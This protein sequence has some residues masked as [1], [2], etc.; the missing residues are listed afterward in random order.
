[1]RIRIALGSVMLLLVLLLAGCGG[2]ATPAPSDTPLPTVQAK[3]TTALAQQPTPPAEPVTPPVERPTATPQN[4]EIV[5]WTV[6]PEGWQEHVSQRWAVSFHVPEDWQEAEPD[7]LA[8]DDGYAILGPFDGPGTSVDQACEWLANYR[9]DL[10][11]LAAGILSV[12][13]ENTVDVGYYPCLIMGGAADGGEGVEYGAAVVLANPAPTSEQA[14]SFLRLD[15][16]PAHALAIARSLTYLRE[17]PP[18][19]TLSASSFG[20]ELAPEEVSDEL[21]LRVESFGNLTLEEYSAVDASVDAPGHFEFVQRIPDA[22]LDT[23]RAWRQAPPEPSL[24]PVQV[25]GHLVAVEELSYEGVPLPG[26]TIYSTYVSVQVDGRE[27]YRYNMALGHAAVFP[28]Y[29]LGSWGG[30]WVVEANGML[31]VDGAIVN[32]DW[33]YQEV[34]G[35]QELNGQ[36]FYFFVEGGKTYLSYGGETL[37]LSYDYVYHGRCCEPAAF[38]AAGN[39]QMVWFYALRDDFWYYVELGAYE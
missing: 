32:Q 26:E 31:I 38:N 22:V 35:C 6:P 39:E 10:Y 36:P 17:A 37:P 27:T 12:P 23:R 29:Y 18:A 28:L 15:V 8:S 34:F 9:R 24:E 21:P 3:P 33:G 19:P 13:R 1:M 11:G 5:D 30:R 7:H 16:D 2:A 25:D 4:E 14:P 20:R